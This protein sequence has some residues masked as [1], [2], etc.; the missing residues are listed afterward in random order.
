MQTASMPH[1]ILFDYGD[2]LLCEPDWNPLRGEEAL[3]QYIK[4]NKRNLSPR[5]VCDYSLQLFGQIGLARSHGFEIHNHAF[6][7]LLYESLEIELTI[8]YPEAEKI[9]WDHAT[10]G[11]VMPQA[12]TM[13]DAINALGIRS[14]VISNISFSGAALAQRLHRLLPNNRFEFI[15]ASSEYVF[16]KPSRLLF[17]LALKKAGLSA[18]EVWFCGDNAK[19]D[20]EGAAQAGIFP[21]WYEHASA[22]TAKQKA[23]VKKPDCEHLHIHEWKELM[24]VLENIGGN[25]AVNKA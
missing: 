22:D 19:A 5:E 18:L 1:M 11:A 9:F 6:Q 17:E 15:I 12:A 7:K 8:S 3:F 14:G 23:A 16:R 21:V 20:I 4:T 2:T 10:P 25:S 24:G 13:L